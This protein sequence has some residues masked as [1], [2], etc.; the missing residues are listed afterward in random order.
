MSPDSS[1]HNST[2]AAAA[3]AQ[4]KHQPAVASTSQAAGGYV[5][6]P[7]ADGSRASQLPPIPASPLQQPHAAHAHQQLEG[8]SHPEITID[9]GAGSST[10]VNGTAVIQSHHPTNAHPGADATAATANGADH[11]E[12]DEISPQGAAQPAG[13]KG[14]Q[15]EE[16]QLAQ[17]A[18]SLAVGA[19]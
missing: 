18:P 5:N 11:S 9:E 4:Q 12:S 10:T 17:V 6:S 15:L 13:L 19:G 8:S 3:L 1:Y 7:S 16:I 14:L 2:E